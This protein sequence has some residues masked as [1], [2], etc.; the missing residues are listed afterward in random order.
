[1]RH[2]QRGISAT[3]LV[4][5]ILAITVAVTSGYFVFSQKL[6]EKLKSINS[7]EECARHYPVMESYPEQCNTPDGKHFTRELS[8]DEKQKLVP[9]PQD[10]A[11]GD[12]NTYQN[13][14]FGFEF[15]YPKNWG[16]SVENYDQ[17]SVLTFGDLVNTNHIGQEVELHPSSRVVLEIQ[18]IKSNSVEKTKNL[19]ATDNP[20]WE[21]VKIAELNAKKVSHMG[22]LSGQCQDIIFSNEKAMFDFWIEN[23]DNQDYQ[24][25][26]ADMTSTFKFLH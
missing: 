17:R 10:T 19:S 22:C 6:N 26:L 16:Y 18:P 5:A 12:R 1:M 24:K 23:S 2:V 15:Q 9:P 14:D 4:I 13:L 8:S 7:F 11:I 3:F 20:K 25:Y 21:N